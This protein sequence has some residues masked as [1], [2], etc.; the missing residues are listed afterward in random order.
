MHKIN[1][2]ICN[3]FVFSRFESENSEHNAVYKH[4]MIAFKVNKNNK[5]AT[6]LLLNKLFV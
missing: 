3:R 5:R 1:M 6:Q 4:R 2:L